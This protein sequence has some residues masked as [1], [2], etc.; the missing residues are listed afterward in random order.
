MKNNTQLIKRN[1]GI[2]FL[3]GICILTVVLLHCAVHIPFN[4]L[5]MP[6]WLFN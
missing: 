1:G 5:I 4:H 3:R 2:D 6:Q